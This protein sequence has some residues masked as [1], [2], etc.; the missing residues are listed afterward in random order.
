MS[1]GNGAPG[2]ITLTHEQIQALVRE[3]VRQTVNET[4]IRLG[5]EVDDP[6]EMQKDFLHLRDWRVT[7]DSVKSKTIMTM[8]GL[9]V[10]GGIAAFVIGFKAWMTHQ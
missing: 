9:I 7:T 1:N 6:I 5:V 3:T 8:L 4:F 10:T 2:N